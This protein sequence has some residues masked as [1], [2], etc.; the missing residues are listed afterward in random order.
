[1][2]C[3]NLFL[4]DPTGRFW[5]LSSGNDG[6]L[7]MT[8]TTFVFTPYSAPVII[9]PSYY[10][11][12]S[13]DTDGTIAATP[14]SPTSGSTSYNLS[15]VLAYN[16]VLTIDDTGVLL[17]TSQG[18]VPPIVVPYPTNISMSKWPNLG[19]VSSVAGNTPLTV[20]AD[21]SIWSCTLNRFINEDTTNLIV[22]LSE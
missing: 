2:S 17:T 20:S 18:L 8:S 19:L 9:S 14:T 6:V 10:W 22:V 5:I 4:K 15:S 1:M 13:A 21:F 7:Q 3:G 12:L 11:V 16:F